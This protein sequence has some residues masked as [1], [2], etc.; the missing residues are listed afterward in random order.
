MKRT[1][2]RTSAG[3]TLV[4]LLVVIGIIALLIS[5][6]LP[7]LNRARQSA[8]TVQ[9]ASNLRQM[10]QGYILYASENRGS[11]PPFSEIG[12]AAAAYNYQTN[13]LHFDF[14][15]PYLGVKDAYAA[16]WGGDKT[17]GVKF[18]NCPFGGPDNEYSAFGVNYT[19][20]FSYPPPQDVGSQKLVKVPLTCFVSMDAS[21]HFIYT[22]YM[23]PGLTVD[24][25]DDG[26]AD[27]HSGL[28]AYTV[29]HYNQARPKRHNGKA[30]YLF[31]DGHVDLR[32]LD[33]W[34]NNEDKIW[35][36]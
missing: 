4:E 16:R 32:T 33:Q 22:P 20:V 36:R 14:I 15:A 17:V 35:G 25:D 11:L 3:F 13:R 34:L 10:G 9:C 27:T 19:E 26:K 5:I 31:P 24:T 1:P 30:N 21:T 12:N 18:L 7:S 29:W 23:S 2:H 6:L 28:T 8:I